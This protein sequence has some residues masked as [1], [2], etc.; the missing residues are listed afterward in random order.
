MAVICLTLHGGLGE[1]KSAEDAGR[2]VP[3]RGTPF[4]AHRPWLENSRLL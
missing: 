4:G 2:K 3:Q 1:E